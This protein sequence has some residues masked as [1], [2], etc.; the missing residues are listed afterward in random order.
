MYIPHH[1]GRDIWPGRGEWELAQLLVSVQGLTREAEWVGQWQSDWHQQKMNKSPSLGKM[2]EIQHSHEPWRGKWVGEQGRKRKEK[3]KWVGERWEKEKTSEHQ[4]QSTR[5]IWL[6]TDSHSIFAMNSASGVPQIWRILVRWS[7]SGRVKVQR[8]KVTVLIHYIQSHSGNT[9]SQ[10]LETVLVQSVIQPWHIRL[11][12]CQLCLKQE[13]ESIN[14]SPTLVL[15]LTFL[16]IVHP[17]E[18]NLWCPPVACHDVAGHS[19]SCL[20]A[21]SKV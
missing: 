6:L 18:H 7:L 1:Q 17:V 14:S 8:T 16:S 10:I 4:S 12:K 9:Y 15:R 21:Q 5:V 13:R 20:S 19:V 11:T 2:E 3:E